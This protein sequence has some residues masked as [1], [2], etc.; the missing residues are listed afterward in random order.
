MKS[1]R[2]GFKEIKALWQSFI[3]SFYAFR[4][5][6]TFFGDTLFNWFFADLVYIILPLAVIFS[7][8]II[9]GQTLEKLYLSPEWSF[10]CIVS[11]GIALTN[12]IEL[13]AERQHDLSIRLYS[14]TAQHLH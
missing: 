3:T 1:R 8:K 2:K 13:K 7:I 10:A 14:I 6:L 9:T 12:T 5:N 11:L 4:K